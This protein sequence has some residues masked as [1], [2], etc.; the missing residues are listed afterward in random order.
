MQRQLSAI[1]SE[2]S[3]YIQHLAQQFSDYSS[4]TSAQ[5][6]EQLAQLQQSHSAELDQVTAQHQADVTSSQQLL[7]NAEADACAQFSCELS[8][9]R[10]Q[11]KCEAAQLATYLTWERDDMLLT[12]AAQHQ[13]EIS[14]LVSQH[15]QQVDHVQTTMMQQSGENLKA[16]LLS[17]E[18]AAQSMIAQGG[19]LTLGLHELHAAEIAFEAS[20]FSVGQAD[21]L[22][23]H[24]QQVQQLELDLQQQLVQAVS[25][26]EEQAAVS[27]T[28]ASELQSQAQIQQLCI[29]HSQEIATLEAT[30]HQQLVDIDCERERDRAESATHLAHALQQLCEEHGSSLSAADA[31]WRDEQQLL[32]RQHQETLLEAQW[33]HDASLERLKVDSAQQ[34]ESINSH[35][36]ADLSQLASEHDSMLTH[37]RQQAEAAQQLHLVST[38]NSQLEHERVESSLRTELQFV[39]QALAQAVSSNARWQAELKVQLFAQNMECTA[40]MPCSPSIARQGHQNLMQS[41]AARMR[42]RMCRCMHVVSE[43]MVQT[44]ASHLRVYQTNVIQVSC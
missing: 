21:R 14:S 28:Q 44:L 29:N 17:S 27:A 43:F 33:L 25:E 13:A 5:A 6:S 19:D 34:L 35:H 26:A 4:R 24:K 20:C 11:H 41:S 8:Y 32:F 9:Q 12:A 40:A 30:H 3:A 37:I 39:K 42:A 15:E 16:V 23:E 36:E 18:Q 22:A 7:V 10:D 2:Q 31:Q 1:E 38:T